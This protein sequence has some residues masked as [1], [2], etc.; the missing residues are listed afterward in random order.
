MIFSNKTYDVLK[1]ITLIVLPALGTAYFALAGIWGLPYADQVSQT[2][3]VICTLLGALLGVSTRNYNQEVG[4]RNGTLELS[5]T[6]DDTV[7]VEQKAAEG[8]LPGVNKS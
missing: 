6:Q 4:L 5:V 1:W 7:A 3:I 2:I 8:D